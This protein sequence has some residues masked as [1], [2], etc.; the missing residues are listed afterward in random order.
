MSTPF[1][2]VVRLGTVPNYGQP[3]RVSVYCKI[4]YTK[5]GKLSISGV[6]GPKSNGDAYGS[7]GQIDMSLREPKGLDGYEPA[8][9]W[10]LGKVRHFLRVWNE[11]HLN[12]MK[13]YDAEM[14]AAGWR[15][16]SRKK[17]VGFEF[18]L[19]RE[20]SNAKTDAEN[21]ALQ[22]LRAGDTFTPTPRQVA[23]ATRP[24]SYTVW[25]Y[26]GEPEPEPVEGYER[27]RDT[28]GHNK[29]NKKYPERKPLGWLSQ[30]EHPDGLLGRALREGGPGYGTQWFKEPVPDTALNFLRALPDT[31]I[32]PA[33]V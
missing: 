24:Y 16:L 14:K 23:D 13:P 10:S 8:P 31:D 29:G 21:A 27:A 19:T 22:A 1:K 6:I 30:K 12:E 3:S 17:M 9:G 4:E 20:A 32:K 5:D 28:Y 26:E 11:W 18:S 7:C 2:K 15:E 25:T 33:W